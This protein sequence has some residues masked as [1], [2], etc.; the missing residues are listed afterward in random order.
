[1]FLVGDDGKEYLCKADNMP[2]GASSAPSSS[3][4]SDSLEQARRLGQQ[5]VWSKERIAVADAPQNVRQALEMSLREN[6]HPEEYLQLRPGS[7]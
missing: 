6:A 5:L 3:P 1:M 2:T 4:S 7:R